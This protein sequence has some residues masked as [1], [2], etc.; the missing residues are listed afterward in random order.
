MVWYGHSLFKMKIMS[1][2]KS[3]Q[4]IWDP[5]R[6]YMGIGKKY[7]KFEMYYCPS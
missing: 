5:K 2:I 7:W 3:N 1:A 4:T 6:P